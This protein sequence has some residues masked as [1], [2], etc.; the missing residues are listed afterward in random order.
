M[1]PADHWLLAHW[2]E[3]DRETIARISDQTW[4]ACA[5]HWLSADD[6]P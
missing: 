2:S 4:M 5:G 3:L 1:L 6:N